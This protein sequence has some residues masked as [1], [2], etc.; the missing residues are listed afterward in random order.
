MR[1]FSSVSRVLACLA[2]SGVALSACGAPTEQSGKSG[3]VAVVA[4]TDV[5]GSIVRHIGG[6]RVEVT[7]II[8]GPSQDP[9][10]YEATV[11]D[12]LAVSEADLVV[13]NGGGYDTFMETLT[14][15]VKTPEDRVLS[16]VEISGL[17]AEDPDEAAHDD[18]S[19]SDADEHHHDHGSFN[20]H[21]WYDLHSMTQLTAELATA[22]G[23]I[24]PDGAAEFEQNAKE[25]TQKLEAL[26]ADL[27]E[28]ETTA[29]ARTVAATEPV[30]LYLL[31]HA[32]LRN[33]TP[34][35]YTEAVEEGSDVS[36]KTLN[37]MERLVADQDIAFLAYNRQTAGPQTES[38]RDAAERAGVPVVNF[39][40]T[41][42][43]GQ[44]YVEWMEHNVEAVTEAVG[45]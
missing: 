40:E 8:S 38:V 41:L 18:E 10:S 1:R 15:S 14:E 13:L 36:V 17:D 12:K 32:G 30:P 26:E 45:Q 44:E 9:H 5:Y 11:R 28:L 3:Q 25:L 31:E 24:D 2:V 21:V 27:A 22:L 7:S 35:A 6:D 37:D 34:A 4:S 20:E 19:P 43:E 33:V 39:T 16:A 42:P 23:E 29:E